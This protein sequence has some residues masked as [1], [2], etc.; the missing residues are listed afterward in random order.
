[1]CQVGVASIEWRCLGSGHNDLLGEDSAFCAFVSCLAE[2]TEFVLIMW[3]GTP[4]AAFATWVHYCF[5][6]D[7]NLNAM[8]SKQEVSPDGIPSSFHGDAA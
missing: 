2:F 8:V 6:G 1:M 4:E 3:E 7:F 5:L